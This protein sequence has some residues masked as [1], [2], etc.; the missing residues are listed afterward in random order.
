MVLEAIMNINI[1]G[2]RK[3]QNELEREIERNFRQGSK[4]VRKLEII[5]KIDT[6]IDKSDTRV[7]QPQKERMANL[8]VSVYK[9]FSHEIK[10]KCA[11]Y[12]DKQAQP[13][14]KRL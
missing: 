3:P 5:D 14:S 2:R 1:E 12:V 11:R 8:S 4:N 13:T 6:V 9:H 10:I 7:S